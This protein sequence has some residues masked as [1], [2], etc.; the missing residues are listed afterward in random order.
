METTIIVTKTPM[1]LV[2]ASDIES[3]LQ[4]SPIEVAM[5]L[6]GPYSHRWSRMM[7]FLKDRLPKEAEKDTVLYKLRNAIEDEKFFEQQWTTYVSAHQAPSLPT[8]LLG[9]TGKPPQPTERDFREYVQDGRLNPIYIK[10]LAGLVDS[11]QK[12]NFLAKLYLTLSPNDRLFSPSDLQQ[13]M[14]ATDFTKPGVDYHDS[15]IL[16]AEMVTKRP[17]G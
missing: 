17:L 14:D 7:W 9:M 11:P 13:I 10:R 3:R 12:L 5:V 16:A 15:L 8:L 1:D 6:K 2:T 4:M